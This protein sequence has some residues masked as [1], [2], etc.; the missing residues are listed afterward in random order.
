MV[1]RDQLAL[2]GHLFQR[3][4]DRAP[5]A[6]RRHHVTDLRCNQLDRFDAKHRGELAVDRRRGAASLHMAEDRDPRFESGTPLEIMRQVDGVVGRVG[7][8]LGEIGFDPVALVVGRSGD[9]IAQLFLTLA[10]FGGPR[11]LGNGDDAEGA[12]RGLPPGAPAPV[13]PSRHRTP[14]GDW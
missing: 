13:L 4:R 12:S 7:T 8:E 10:V 11:S 6:D 3:Y 5:A 2:S 1:E 9:A 14:W